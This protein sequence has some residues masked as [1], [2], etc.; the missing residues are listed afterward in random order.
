MRPIVSHLPHCV[1]ALALLSCPC[2]GDDGIVAVTVPSHDVTLSFVQ[3]GRVVKVSVEPGDAVASGDALV[4][5]DDQREVVEIK[6]QEAEVRKQEA[7]IRKQE[8]EIKKQRVES[9]KLKAQA[10]DTIRVDAAR[11]RR[12]Q[13]RV[14]LAKLKEAAERGAATAKELQHAELDV[15]IAELSL[16]LAEFERGQAGYAHR[17]AQVAIKQAQAT[18]E[19][20]AVGVEQVKLAVEQ[21]KLQRER[22][23][24]TSPVDGIVE[25]VLVEKGEAVNAL[26]PVL[27]I[28]RID[29]LWID[30]PVPLSRAGELARGG[31]V[32]VRL[33]LGESSPRRTGRIIHVGA[34]ADAASETLAVRVA[35]SN[36]DRRPA[37]EAV[38]VRFP[39]EE[40]KDGP[41]AP[42]TEAAERPSPENDS[43]EE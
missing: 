22:R 1:A 20:A 31:E 2:L 35:V 34:V 25:E 41:D 5:Q 9:E 33:G 42:A 4:H 30:V 12:D 43:D 38:R 11:A 39:R 26:D 6:T 36:P 14:D 19:M 17:Q 28:V 18:V 40:T 13:S 16:A 10:E 24:L 27:R 7:E 15:R 32:E 21:A 8:A 23:R 37:G 3:P 29:P